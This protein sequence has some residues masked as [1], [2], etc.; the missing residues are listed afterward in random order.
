MISNLL[1]LPEKLI[2]ENRPEGGAVCAEP[3]SSELKSARYSN[4]LVLLMC[5]YVSFNVR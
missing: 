3:S 2:P 4:R 1:L 5:R